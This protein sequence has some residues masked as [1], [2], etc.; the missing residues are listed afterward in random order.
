M[1]IAF[2]LDCG[3]AIG[4]GHL[5]R[6]GALAEEFAAQGCEVLFVCGN[7]V[8][9]PVAV[10][11]HY[12]THA[13]TD[14]C[15]GQ[16]TFPSIE[17]EAEELIEVLKENKVSCLIVDH[18]GATPAYFEKLRPHVE[19][20]AAIDDLAKY[21]LPVDVVINGNLYADERDYETVPIRLC[22]PSYTLLRRCFRH[23]GRKEIRKRIQ[24][25]YITSGGADPLGLCKKLISACLSWDREAAVFHIIIGPSF[26][27]EYIEELT[28]V[29][30]RH[31][32]VKLLYM[33]DMADCMRQADLFITASGSTLYEL[34]AC[35][36]PNISVVLAE[37]QRELA[38]EMH[39]LG[40][41]YNIGEIERIKDG[42]FSK[43]VAVLDSAAVRRRMG[44]LGQS[45]IDGYGTY[46]AA[47]QI[48]QWIKEKYYG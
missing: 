27:P 42:T 10:P 19:C 35:G 23:V 48:N 16:Y 17:D 7:K 38:N 32:C 13:Y 5:I 30:A 39:R 46:R 8:T 33:A 14:D 25:I 28:A 11:V 37:D 18:Y 44:A 47:C 6:C 22:G 40:T 15:A 12:L 41:T 3:A 34:A 9:V 24:D 21:T 26:Q 43:A 2:R 31:P 45:L 1:K 20:L 36:V 4:S 29:A